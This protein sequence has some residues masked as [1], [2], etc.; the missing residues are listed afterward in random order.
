MAYFGDK[1]IPG[2]ILRIICYFLGDT[3]LFFTLAFCLMFSS[4]FISFLVL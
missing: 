2:T 1:V 4:C 3:G